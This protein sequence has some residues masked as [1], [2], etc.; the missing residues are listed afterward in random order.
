[1][2][3]HMVDGVAD[4][5]TKALGELAIL[6]RV[7]GAEALTQQVNK[8]RAEGEEFE[9]GVLAGPANVVDVPS[10]SL[11]YPQNIS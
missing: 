7:E 11:L 4:K 3:R 1:M 5:A 6:G 2:V 8:L 10:V 9:D